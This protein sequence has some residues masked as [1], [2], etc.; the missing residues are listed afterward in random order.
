MRR[1]SDALNLPAHWFLRPVVSRDSGPVFYRCMASATTKSARLRAQSRYGWLKDVVSLV[2][3]YVKMPVVQLPEFKLPSDPTQLSNAHIEELAAE[4]R[5]FWGL[6]DGP[7]SNVVWLLE[8]RGC[9]VSRVELHAA[10]LDAFSEFDPVENRPY[11]VLSSDKRSAARSRFDAAHE[12]AHLLLHRNI[13]G[14]LLTQHD[15]FQLIEQQAHY[16]A[17]AFLLPRSSFGRECYNITL[18]AF[19]SLKERWRVSISAMVRRAKELRIVNDYQ[20][21]NLSANIGRRRWRTREPLDDIL[22]PERPRFLRKCFE[23]LIGKGIQPGSEA[24]TM[25]GIPAAEIEELAGLE[26]GYLGRADA[27]I[28]LTGDEEAVE[29]DCATI[30]RFP[31]QQKLG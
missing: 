29:E 7:I 2:Q 26:R 16:F 12:L 10:A 8:N 9:I 30:I 22:E 15:S 28:T 25:L 23:L 13:D 31:Y 19:R 3:Q 27:A 1:I 6:K 24:P 18:D 14:G 4:T 20:Y 11:V 21:R 5:R 17:G